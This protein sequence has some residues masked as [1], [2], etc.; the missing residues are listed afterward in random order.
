MGRAGSPT[1]PRPPQSEAV[2]IKT[3][4]QPQACRSLR[5]TGPDGQTNGQLV[6]AVSPVPSSPPTDP[7]RREPTVQGPL[8]PETS[9]VGFWFPTAH[10]DSDIFPPS[11]TSKRFFL[12]AC[13][14]RQNQ[15]PAGSTGHLQ[16]WRAAPLPPTA[17]LSAPALVVS[18][19][20]APPVPGTLS[21]AP[22]RLDQ[23]GKQAW[24]A[25]G[26]PVPVPSCGAAELIG[27]RLGPE[28]RPCL[29]P[30]Q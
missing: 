15:C 5:G 6:L 27:N 10:N 8:A 2:F 20:R 3:L 1:P 24:Q 19:L 13:C 14:C 4:R 7:R 12:E 17:P 26:E 28:C 30:R 9:R 23:R 25:G 21:A 22:A 29:W 16:L 18:R 11:L